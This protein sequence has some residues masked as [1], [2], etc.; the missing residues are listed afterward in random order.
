M[1]RASS[2]FCTSTRAPF[3]VELSLCFIQLRPRGPTTGASASMRSGGPFEPLAGCHVSANVASESPAFLG[4]LAE[5]RPEQ[6][7]HPKRVPNHQPDT[8]RWP[9]TSIPTEPGNAMQCFPFNVFCVGRS[10]TTVNVR[11]RAYEHN[12]AYD[13]QAHMRTQARAPTRAPT[14][15]RARKRA[16]FTH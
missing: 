7:K 5:S 11:V 2:M 16:T 10:K 9:P 14:I 15:T 4:K 13:A 8:Q 6:N 12:R 3:C 1:E